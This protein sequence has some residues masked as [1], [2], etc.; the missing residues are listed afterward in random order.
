MSSNQ[1]LGSSDGRAL[2]NLLFDKSI[3]VDMVAGK[4]RMIVSNVPNELLG[5]G[6]SNKCC[7]VHECDHCSLTG[8]PTDFKVAKLGVFNSPQLSVNSLR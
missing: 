1:P 6:P 4:E 3:R 8:R 7:V 5:A 2:D